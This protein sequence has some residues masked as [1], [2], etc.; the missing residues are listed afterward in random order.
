M[1]AILPFVL[2]VI[3]LA[4][5]S[6]GLAVR[7]DQDPN[8]DFSRYRTWGFF[9]E[10]G[11]EGGNNS[12]VFGEHFRAAITREMNARGYRQSENPDL[13]VNVTLRADDKVKMKSYTAPYTSGAYYHRPGSRYYGS[14]MA[15]GVGSV[16]RATEVT[17][18][19]IFIDL[20]D[21]SSDRLVW[22]GVAVAEATDS[23]AKRLRDAVHTA[24]DR[25]FR[26]Y[27]YTAGE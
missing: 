12:P 2:V 10:L 24:V 18:A 5:C 15:V 9:N 7:S 26:L 13:Y 25:V 1:K 17:E 27:P 6:S 22:Q 14:S 19:S 8:A 23:A 11:I 21:N 20:V 3:S 16:S 4:A